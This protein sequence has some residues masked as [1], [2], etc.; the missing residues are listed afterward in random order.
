[1]SKDFIKERYGDFL[2]F[3]QRGVGHILE[4]Y[5]HYSTDTER[6]IQTAKV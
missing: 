1:M 5:G 4:D 3:E 2:D 6:T